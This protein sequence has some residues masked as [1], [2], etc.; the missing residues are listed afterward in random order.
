MYMYVKEIIT[1]G[2]INQSDK[3]FIKMIQGCGG[4]VS[5]LGGGDVSL[6]H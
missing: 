5:L 3:I 4:G 6:T 1:V 2:I